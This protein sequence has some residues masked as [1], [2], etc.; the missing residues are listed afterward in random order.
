MGKTINSVVN[1]TNRQ[2]G[3]CK[4]IEIAKSLRLI[5]SGSAVKWKIPKLSF[6]AFCFP[7]RFRQIV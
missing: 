2:Y 1:L 4:C 6:P 5:P 7:S 3:K